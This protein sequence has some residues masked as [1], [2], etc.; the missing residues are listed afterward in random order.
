MKLSCLIGF[1]PHERLAKQILT[2]NLKLHL[3]HLNA[4]VSDCL[5]DTVDYE[6]LEMHLLQVAEQSNC[7]LIERLA[8]L[9]L[10]ACLKFDK[11]I[12]SAELE[13]EKPG[14]LKH[15]KSA[16]VILAKEAHSLI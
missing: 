6:Q 14:C 9:L 10:D 11:R 4:R 16:G 1:H 3:S 7:L 12:H 2:L 13:L 8:Q 15:A 5:K